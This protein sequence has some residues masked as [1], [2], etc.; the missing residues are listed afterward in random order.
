MNR[1]K[2]NRMN[3]K[4]LAT[5]G[6]F[7][8]LFAIFLF[9][10]FLGI[11]VFF[12][13]TVSDNLALD[14]EIGQV[15]LKEVHDA[16]FGTISQ[17]LINN[18]DLIGYTVI[19]A[20]VLS[21]FLNAYLTR[22]QFPKLFIIVDIVILVFAYILSYYLRMTYSLLIHSTSLLDVYITTI[23]KTSTFILNLPLIVGI[24]GAIVMILSYS[25]IPRKEREIS[26]T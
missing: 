20:L 13:K 7:L 18:A 5:I 11:V 2:M 23:P 25:G 26:F 15:N 19:L 16:T 12:Y 3:K 4:G 6:I 21:L 9:A 17:G 24:I 1:M 14:I 10:I 22:D 8:F